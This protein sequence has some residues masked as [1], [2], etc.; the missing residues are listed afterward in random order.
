MKKNTFR[1]F[2]ITALCLS[3]FSV[4]AQDPPDPGEDPDAPIDGG[5]GLLL[6]AGAA[7]GYKTLTKKEKAE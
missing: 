3:S 1:L 6:A 5:I 4:F 2:L 7:Y